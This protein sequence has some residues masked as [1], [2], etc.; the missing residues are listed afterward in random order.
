MTRP[1]LFQMHR[2]LTSRALALMER[3]NHD[4]AGADGADPFANF[5]VAESVGI[6][7]T[8]AGLL[9]R[10]TDKLKRIVEFTKSGELQVKDE[11]VEDT[12]ID[13]INY[14][15]LLRAYLQSQAGA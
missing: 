2:D 9:V 14:L 5:R 4:Y 6:C 11:S 7:T 15:V 1:E 12:I 13:G 10:L 8:E 3:K